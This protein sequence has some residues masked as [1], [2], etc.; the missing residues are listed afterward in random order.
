MRSTLKASIPPRGVTW[1]SICS[2]TVFHQRS[3]APAYLLATS[4]SA[5]IVNLEGP[6][7]ANIRASEA[8]FPKPI[9]ALIFLWRIQENWLANDLAFCRCSL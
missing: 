6:S 2:R 7:R 9:A 4:C 5:T 3:T 8:S 1:F